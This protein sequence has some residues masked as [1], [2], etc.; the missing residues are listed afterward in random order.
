[1]KPGS[2]PHSACA[3]CLYLISPCIYAFF[4]SCKWVEESE[5]VSSEAAEE[6]KAGAKEREITQRQLDQSLF[7]L[8]NDQMLSVDV[9]KDMEERLSQLS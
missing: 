2:R 8:E 3:H 5:D 6:A 9:E 7:V 4:G 1:M